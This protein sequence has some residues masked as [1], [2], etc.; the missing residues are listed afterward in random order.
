MVA[1]NWFIILMICDI[2]SMSLTFPREV[3]QNWRCQWWVSN[4]SPNNVKDEHEAKMVFFN[5]SEIKLLFSALGQW[6]PC[7][8]E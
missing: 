3:Q 2:S 4:S 8:T 7:F 5:V 6:L 1:Y